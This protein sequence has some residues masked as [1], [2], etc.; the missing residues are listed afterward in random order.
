VSGVEC[1]VSL[2]SPRHPTLTLY[3]FKTTR[4]RAEDYT[5]EGS[6]LHAGGFETTRRRVR[7]YTP[8][9]SNYS[10]TAT[11]RAIIVA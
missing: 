6:R 9:G 3:P 4:R 10:F 2:R 1:R 5:P 7:D 11:K 8:E